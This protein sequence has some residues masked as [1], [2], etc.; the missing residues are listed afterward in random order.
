MVLYGLQGASL[1]TFPLMLGVNSFP[2]M[3]L[4]GS[5]PKGRLCVDI[6]AILMCREE[7][8][9]AFTRFRLILVSSNL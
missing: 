4:R 9:D 3:I 2:R 6:L 5:S 1:G 8:E 7:K